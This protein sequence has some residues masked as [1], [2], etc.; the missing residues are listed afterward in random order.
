[1][2]DGITDM[3]R[4]SDAWLIA[5]RERLI[6]E[7]L[8]YGE[9]NP[10]L[11]PNIQTNERSGDVFCV[12]AGRLL[13]ECGLSWCQPCQAFFGPWGAWRAVGREVSWR[14]EVIS[15]MAREY[16]TDRLNLGALF[17]SLG[18]YIEIRIYL[19]AVGWSL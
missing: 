4:A 3:I 19:D 15:E 12:H 14:A 11:C 8:L 13:G 10:G 16:D 6:E 17:V 2:S 5:M 9:Y 7:D 18:M 1:M